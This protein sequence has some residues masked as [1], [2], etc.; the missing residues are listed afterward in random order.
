MNTGINLKMEMFETNEQKNATSKKIQKNMFQYNRKIPGRRRDDCIQN[1]L[2]ST[3]FNEIPLAIFYQDL[4]LRYISVNQAFAQFVGQSPEN[5]V[6]KSVTD[7]FPAEQAEKLQAS[8]KLA[9]KTERKLTNIYQWPTNDHGENLY[10]SI[11][12]APFYDNEGQ[13]AGLVG[14]HDDISHSMRASLINNNL[15]RENR[16]LTQKLFSV[17]EDER[18]SLARDLHDELGQWLIAIQTEVEEIKKIAGKNKPLQSSIRAVQKYAKSMHKVIRSMLQ[19]LRPVLLDTLGLT[20]CLYEQ[21]K[22][23]STR[24]PEID[25]ELVI[26]DDFKNIDESISIIVYRIIQEAL[27]NVCLHAQATKVQICLSR[28]K[29]EYVNLDHLCLRIKDNGVGFDPNKDA[30]GYGLLGMRERAIA[31]CGDFTLRSK[32]GEGTLILAKLP[33]AGR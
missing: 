32:P 15:L 24:H 23:W 33:L 2:K 5:I 6:G 17:Q 13:I 8:Y 9:L 4:N 1:A 29:N 3:L 28:E 12:I 26:E 20:L 25:Y 18:R 11:F 30:K 21:K 14:T 7:L 16:L 27:N 22:D 31:A 19:K 10:L